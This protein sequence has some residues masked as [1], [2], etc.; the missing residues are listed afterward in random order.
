MKKK[1]LKTIS[2]GDLEKEIIGFTEEKILPFKAWIT[3]MGGDELGFK[4]AVSQCVQYFGYISSM[5]QKYD[6]PYDTFMEIVR[7]VLPKYGFKE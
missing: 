7:K 1:E 2:L 4:E 5:E 3:E 6:T